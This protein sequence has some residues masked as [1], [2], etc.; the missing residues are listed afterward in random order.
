MKKIRYRERHNASPKEGH[1]QAWDEYQVLDGRKIIGR[2]DTE[3][4][5]KK[6]HPD[7]MTA[8][9]EADLHPDS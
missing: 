9:E 8:E 1:R 4:Q 5:A 7:A 6:A 3:A 2:Y